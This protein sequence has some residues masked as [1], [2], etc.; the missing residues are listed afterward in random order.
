MKC[1]K[2]KVDNPDDSQFRRKCATPLTEIPA[3]LTSLPT[4][5]SIPI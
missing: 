5:H 3:T 4:K 2:C 1:P